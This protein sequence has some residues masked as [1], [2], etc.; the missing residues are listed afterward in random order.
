LIAPLTLAVAGL[1]SLIDTR[2]FRC[3][4]IALVLTLS[5]LTF[6][7]AQVFATDESLFR[8]SLAKNPA[9]AD[10]HNDLGVILAKR[11]N[12]AEA[13]AH[14][15]AAVRSDPGNA[16]AQSN[17]GQALAIS[18]KF[19]EAEPHFLAAIRLKPG[20]PLVHRHFADALSRQGRNREAVLHLQ[21]ALSLDAKPDVQTRLD[22][23][24]LL[25]RTGNA[26]QAA[27]QFRRVL[28]SNPDLPE[29][30]NNLAWILATSPDDTLRDG[31]EAVRCAEHAC[32]LTAFKQTGMI[33]TLAA[34]YAEAGRYSEAVATAEMAV[35]LQTANGETQLAG[36]N[37]QL[38]PL[39]R[40]GIPYH[41]R[42]Q[43]VK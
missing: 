16:G 36:I 41:E 38:L 19:T 21:A 8:D 3:V 26:R 30:L 31:A 39:Y 28:S 18:G 11:K 5:V 4:A 33:S 43:P 23:A 2:I 25:F 7:R 20:D 27:E 17:L 12:Y 10:M 9:A 14:F 40:A 6:Q 13:A 29:P 24:G 35:R 32:R 22:L 1:A 42:R 15:V 37:N 34:A